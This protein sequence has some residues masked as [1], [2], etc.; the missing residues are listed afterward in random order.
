MAKGGR[1]YIE[2]MIKQYGTDWLVSVNPDSIQRSTKR[3]IKDMVNSTMD[4]GKYGQY[5]LESKFLENII[6]A[7]T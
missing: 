4:Y 7:C 3:I 6:I 5:F 1:T 2:T